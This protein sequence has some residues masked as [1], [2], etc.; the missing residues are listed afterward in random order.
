MLYSVLPS[1]LHSRQVTEDALHDGEQEMEGRGPRAR[2]R[3]MLAS[4]P[5]G[6]LALDVAGKAAGGAAYLKF[7]SRQG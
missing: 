6:Q 4:R 3:A 7:E 2:T 5:V 1:A